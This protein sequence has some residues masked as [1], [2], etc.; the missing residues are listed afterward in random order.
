MVTVLAIALSGARHVLDRQLL[1]ADTRSNCVLRQLILALATAT[2]PHKGCKG[3]GIHSVDEFGG[4]MREINHLRERIL[5]AMGFVVAA[6]AGGCT[7][8]AGAGDDL[9]AQPNDVAVKKDALSDAE[10]KQTKCEGMGGSWEQKHVY[11]AAQIKAGIEKRTCYG[12][13]WEPMCMGSGPQPDAGALPDCKFEYKG[14]LPPEGCPSGDFVLLHCQD[15]T[16]VELQGD[17]CVFTVCNTCV[18]GR[19]FLVA[20]TSRTAAL[21]VAS[22]WRS[23]KFSDVEPVDAMAGLLAAAWRAD[24]LDEHASVAS[25]CQFTLELLHFGAPP[26]MILAATLAAADEVEHALLCLAL[27]AQLDNKPSGPGC[28][29]CADLRIAGDLAAAAAAAVVQG[30]VGETLAALVAGSAARRATEPAVVE[31]LARITEDETRHAELAWRFVRWACETGGEP[32]RDAVRVA[33]AHA[34]L[35]PPRPD[36]RYER[37]ASVSAEVQHRWG[38]L[39]PAEFSRLAALAVDQVI[40]PCAEKLLQAA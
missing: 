17:K 36:R 29:P 12:P 25:F 10:V 22:E 9:D 37:L 2:R 30:C 28:L 34:L 27:A 35:V 5:A 1:C 26:A 14:I 3:R 31:A 23:A 21:S 33:F 13:P 4:P 20:G 32:V 7:Q 11:T 38:R 16:G 40:R 8:A 19:P 39:T 18:C 6:T 24:A 15:L